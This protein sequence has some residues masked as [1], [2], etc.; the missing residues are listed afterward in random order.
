MN[1]DA[2]DF[3]K[4]I[5]IQEQ[6]ANT[7]QWTDLTTCYARVLKTGGSKSMAAGA[8]QFHASLTF[9]IRYRVK[10]KELVFLP[11][12]YRVVYGG[13]TFQ[14]VDADDYQQQHETIRIVG[15]LY[16]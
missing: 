13:H 11:Q 15:E 3:D 2:G 10:L 7:E 6:N 5:I 14:A 16:E 4:R 12:R 8:D 9:E 1:L